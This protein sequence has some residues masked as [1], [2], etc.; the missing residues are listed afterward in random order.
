M[1]NNYFPPRELRAINALMQHPMP[2]EKLDREAGCSNSPELVSNLRRKGLEI[3]CERVKDRDRDGQ[4]IRRGVYYLTV[5]DR[6]RI[7]MWSNL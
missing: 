3:P 2:R 6:D 1:L 4:E 5:A 7:R